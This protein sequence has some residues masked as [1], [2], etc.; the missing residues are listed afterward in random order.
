MVKRDKAKSEM[1]ACDRLR[2]GALLGFLNAVGHRLP[3]V[4]SA[5]AAAAPHTGAA[6][7]NR[8]RSVSSARDLDALLI[9]HG[10]RVQSSDRLAARK[11]QQ[12]TSS[13]GPTSVARSVS[14]SRSQEEVQSEKPPA[15]ARRGAKAVKA[16]GKGKY[17]SE[18]SEGESSSSDQEVESPK[19]AIS[20]NTTQQRAAS[21]SVDTM[22]PLSPSHRRPTRS[23]SVNGPALS[24]ALE[25]MEGFRTAS[26][27]LAPVNAARSS[28]LPSSRRFLN[29][30]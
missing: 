17:V 19:P 28:V 23:S 18:S 15:K 4:K 10:E 25:D 13:Q 16:K 8:R 14:E 12:R 6:P 9:V 22:E 24:L 2:A 21:K 27:E 7:S 20:R 30:A 1:R 11:R 29:R 26:S 3:G 5:V